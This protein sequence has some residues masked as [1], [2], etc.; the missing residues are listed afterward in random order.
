[1]VDGEVCMVMVIV[2]GGILNVG[3]YYYVI[4]I[5]NDVQI[6]LSVGVIDN[7]YMLGDDLKNFIQN[8]ILSVV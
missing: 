5:I 2:F 6:V 7:G 1:M 3:G 4:L 8:N